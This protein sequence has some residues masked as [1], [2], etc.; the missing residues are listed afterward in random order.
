MDLN[1]NCIPWRPK[2]F[3]LSMDILNATKQ[4]YKYQYMACYAIY[5]CILETSIW[6]RRM[7]KV[8]SMEVN[9]KVVQLVKK[10]PAFYKTQT[11]ITIWHESATAPQPE[12][13][14][15]SLHDHTLFLWHPKSQR[16]LYVQPALILQIYTQCVNSVFMFQMIVRINSNY[17]S[18][19]H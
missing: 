7:M 8:E 14:Q 19:E 1:A 5:W 13:D 15:S 12:P 17:F 4:I 9:R 11:F 10:L 18:K 16:L 2:F 6:S 3:W